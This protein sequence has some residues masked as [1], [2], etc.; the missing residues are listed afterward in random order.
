MSASAM[1]GTAALP[2][3]TPPV[4]GFSGRLE[5]DRAAL[6]AHITETERLL[7][8]LRPR[9]L[10][11][12][13]QQEAA[14]RL[15]GGGRAARSAFLAL[16]AEGVYDE[17]TARRTR[18]LRLPELIRA[19]ADEFPGLVPTDAQMAAEN[20]YIQAEKDGREIDQ[21]I[22]CGAILRSA[23]AGRHLIEAMLRPTPRALELL[24]DYRAEG[25]VELSSVLVERRGRAGHVTFRNAHCL[26]AETNEL[27]GDLETAVDLV[28]MDD[29]T[30]V[31]VLR[32][33]EVDH[34]R[35][36]GRRVFSAGINLKD[37][38]QGDISFVD[39]LMGR[40]LGYINK[41]YRGLLSSPEAASWGERVQQKPWV[42]A[43]DAFAI[44]GG[45]QLLLVLDRVIAEEGAYFSLPAAEEGIVPGLGNLRLSRFTGART[46]RQVILGGRRI[47]T[48]DPEFR[49][50]CDEVV[51]PCD[52][53]DAVERAVTELA[54]P[55]VAANRHML[56]LVEEPLDLY[57]EYLAEFAVVQVA[58]SYSED[59]LAKV[60]RRWQRSRGGS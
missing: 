57:R 4:P 55:A 14:E 2:L 3:G 39:F 56:G 50:L 45:M 36:E 31:G 13:A 44:G 11:T 8:L 25:R 30:A 34:P 18:H 15:L 26:N 43:V 19:A 60:E 9:P 37:L 5:P 51:A 10:R 16:H 6:A 27:I 59:V 21:A 33:G 40:E 24:S 47:G 32:G 48:A 28:L 12:P 58:R 42:G 23:T 22:F 7:A 38:R 17:L 49:L 35:Y 46:A 53:A 1:A 54:A 41:M 20:E 52:M 29:A